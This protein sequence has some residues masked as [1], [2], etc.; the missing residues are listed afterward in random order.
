MNREPTY[1]KIEIPS[2]LK[3]EWLKQLHEATQQVVTKLAFQ[4]IA[5]Y[6]G[7]E[8]NENE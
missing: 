5:H 8:E 2:G 1:L 6:G 3:D 4:I 7:E